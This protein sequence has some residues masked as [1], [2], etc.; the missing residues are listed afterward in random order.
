M[1]ALIWIFLISQA[2]F[3]Q[4]W[5]PKC[6]W[7]E[8]LRICLYSHFLNVVI[9]FV[10]Y[11]TFV[12]ND[13]TNSEASV[14]NILYDV[15]SKDPSYVFW[16]AW[17]PAAFYGLIKERRMSTSCVIFTAC[18]FIPEFWKPST[19]CIVNSVL[20]INLTYTRVGCGCSTALVKF[21][22]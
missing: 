18:V 3:T 15:E 1:Q 19:T 7:E 6:I 2:S 9:R 20:P 11:S 13:T 14:S 21:V 8:W 5:K 22:Q 16:H 12:K 4:E 10:R 17:I